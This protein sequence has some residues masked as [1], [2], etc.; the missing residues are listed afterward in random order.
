MKFIEGLA[1]ARLDEANKAVEVNFSGEG[2]IPVYQVAVQVALDMAADY[3]VSRLVFIKQN[4]RDLDSYKFLSYMKEWLK[5][6]ANDDAIEIR[7]I[8]ILTKIQAVRKM[9][10]LLKYNNL[11]NKDNRVNES[12]S[13]SI[14]LIEEKPIF[15][16][17][18][19]TA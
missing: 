14:A 16:L 1:T 3:K 9:N 13:I 5:P 10:M 12:L 4:F 18:Q 7:E 2:D 6:L 17:L 19:K 15:P 8:L 11:Y